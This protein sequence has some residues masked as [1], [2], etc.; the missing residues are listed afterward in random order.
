MAENELVIFRVPA[1]VAEL[2][3]F[4]RAKGSPLTEQEVLKIRDKG[5]AI[6]LPPDEAANVEAARGYKDINSVNCWEEWQRVRLVFVDGIDAG[7][8]KSQKR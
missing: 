6:K 2:C 3:Y 8:C 1:L 4:E 7:D 5:V